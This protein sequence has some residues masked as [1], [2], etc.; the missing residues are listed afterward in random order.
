M[1]KDLASMAENR[2]KNT[3]DMLFNASTIEARAWS[4]MLTVLRLLAARLPGLL[5][6]ISSLAVQPSGVG[7]SDALSDCG[8]ISSDASRRTHRV[9]NKLTPE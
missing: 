7:R 6:E 3:F 4:A 5:T 8:V 9:L 2:G 1:N